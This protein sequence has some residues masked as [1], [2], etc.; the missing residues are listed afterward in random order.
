MTTDTELTPPP[1]IDNSQY[2]AQILDFLKSM[3]PTGPWTITQI[4]DGLNAATFTDRDQGA[5]VRWLSDRN[6]KV[7]LYFNI[8]P[9][10][11]VNTK[12]SLHHVLSVPRLHVDM[13]PRKGKS[14]PAER[15]LI[16][17]LIND[18]ALLKA[19]GLPGLPS[20][21]IDSGR[22]FWAFWELAEPVI[23][24]AQGEG[25]RR[26]AA[27]EI[28]RYNR[29]VTEQ[30]NMALNSLDKDNSP[31]G[32][33]IV[34]HCHNIDRIA[35]LP[36]TTNFPKPEKVADGAEV[37]FASVVGQW[38][39]TYHLDQFQKSDVISHG[40]AATKEELDAVEVGGHIITLPGREFEPWQ[41]TEELQRQ[42]PMVGAKCCE[43]IALGHY[44]DPEV[45]NDNIDDKAVDG[46]MHTNRSR[47]HWRANRHLQ[48]VGV[49]LNVIVGLLSD[50]RLPI[51]DHARKPFDEKANR[52]KP[53]RTFDEILRFN[54][55]Q[56]RRATVSIRNQLKREAE[57][58]ALLTG[59]PAAADSTAG[60]SSAAPGRASSVP[61]GNTNLP[62]TVPGVIEFMNRSHAVLLQE[63][64]K[65]RVLSW[66]RSEIDYS[67]EIPVL[68]TFADFYNRYMHRQVQVGAKKGEPVVKTWAEVWLKNA[69]R[70]EF[71]SLRFLPGQ[72]EEVD[73]YLNMW[74]GFAVEPQ[75]G[76]WSL[77]KDHIVN[78]LA[79][80]NVEV[81][82][83]ILNW[84]AWAVQHPD[85]PAE[86]ALVFKGQKGTGKG[87]FARAIKRLFG[88]HGLQI[89]SPAQLTGRF[90]AHLRDCCLLF[91]DEAIVPEDKKAESVLKGLITEPE[92]AVEGKGANVI[93][94]RN[95]LHIIMASNEDWVIPAGVDERRFAVFE[96]E[97][98]YRGDRAY[99]KALTEQMNNGGLAAMLHAFQAR[100]ISNWHPR[101]NI[102]KTEALRAQKEKS[103]KPFDAFMINVAEEGVLP[104]LPF[105]GHAAAVPSNDR[106][107]RLG[108]FTAI[109]NSTPELKGWSDKRL[110]GEM[111]R[112]GCT[113]FSNGNKRGWEFP[114][115]AAIR[116]FIDKQFWD[117]SW[118]EQDAWPEEDRPQYDERMFEHSVF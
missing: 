71:L 76:D 107:K 41:I 33:Q 64:G 108:L 63:G 30:L 65:T 83:Y 21:V 73:G 59:S 74:R 49:P 52:W 14:I 101:D 15:A 37:S 4:K 81:A 111:R 47:A 54:E 104:V 8:N 53:E 117:I 86:V 19:A 34:D 7:N 26:E 43:L 55:V 6:G 110:A 11:I 97:D 109:R 82:E 79:G 20:C 88:Q 106:G 61:G 39:R 118:Q 116:T 70:R 12:A 80:G 69:R 31:D 112:W 99:F 114:P 94:A 28:G 90:N 102:P 45:G 29:W 17:R 67:R 48:Q 98:Q 35:R 22:G 3:H 77:M 105:E 27:A 62:S 85:E 58:T 89:T 103:L 115:L 46:A 42:Y 78:V 44:L 87:V 25:P 18:E 2:S 91:A 40:A 92:L 23:L 38:D 72:P 66:E 36:F 113:R 75:A 93:Q 10:S 5:L 56:V 32:N 96:V 68:Q 50:P 84:A 100:D 24:D 9:I 13:D 57:F 60:S 16:Q 95:R 51:S 1:V